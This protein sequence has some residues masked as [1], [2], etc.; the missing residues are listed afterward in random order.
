MATR[1]QNEGFRVLDD[2]I[3]EALHDAAIPQA[4]PKSPGQN[5]GVR[6][7]EDLAL[8][9]SDG[10]E[11]PAATAPGLVAGESEMGSAQL[12]GARMEQRLQDGGVVAGRMAHSFDNILTGILGFVELTVSQ[13]TPGSLPYRYLSEV[14]QAA[15][16]GAQLTQQL[17]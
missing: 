5:E 3:C 13:M 6:V 12:D 9:G 14:L 2:F 15:Q 17:H 1:G 10:S 4:N 11:Q 7:L 16:Q 8:A